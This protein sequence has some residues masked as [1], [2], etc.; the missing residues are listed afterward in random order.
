MSLEKKLYTEEEL[1]E[2]ME[3]GFDYGYQKGFTDACA[4]VPE[5][6]EDLF[7]K[8]QSIFGDWFKENKTDNHE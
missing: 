4:D 2:A 3:Y 8:D 5:Y 7:N 6:G 1:K